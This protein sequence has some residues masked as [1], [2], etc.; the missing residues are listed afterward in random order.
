M[1]YISKASNGYAKVCYYISKWL[2]RYKDISWN[3]WGFQNY[4]QVQSGNAIR[5]EIPDD[6]KII[7]AL[8]LEKEAGVQGNGFGERVIGKHLKE[9]PYDLI[10]NSMT[11]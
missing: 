2:G 6:V 3:V 9:N 4:N 10:I 8:K 7:D 11:Q 1:W 5:N